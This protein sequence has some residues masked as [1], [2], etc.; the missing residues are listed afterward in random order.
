MLQTCRRKLYLRVIPVFNYQNIQS[1]LSSSTETI[2]YKKLKRKKEANKKFKNE[3]ALLFGPKI[4]SGKYHSGTDQEKTHIEPQLKE[5]TQSTPS[6]SD[7]YARTLSPFEISSDLVGYLEK[8][9][10]IND[11]EKEMKKTK[12]YLDGILHYPLSGECDSSLSYLPQDLRNKW[13]SVTRI[14][15]KSRPPEEQFYLDRWKEKMIEKLGQDGFAQMQKDT[16]NRGSLL[17]DCI[18]AKLQNQ[19]V[20]DEKITKIEPLWN[21]VRNI[22]TKVEDV[23]FIEQFFHHQH[24]LYKGKVDC[25]A[26]FQG[27]VYVI[28]WKTS[29]KPKRSLKYT[30][31][32]PTQIAAYI[33]S[34]NSQKYIKGKVYGA[35][36]VCYTNGDEADVHLMDENACK[37]YWVKWLKRLHVYWE[38]INGELK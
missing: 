24:L 10:Q 32:A 21:S 30:W 8:N 7:S 1:F 28:D 20:S 6:Q 22:L 29:E 13:P 5:V 9:F 33:G 15:D 27:D 36:I 26:T 23:H 35:V 11:L 38:K 16:L 34:I 17:H 25:V 3:N 2:N 19:I 4:I 31:D 18:E 12:K 37:E 14:L